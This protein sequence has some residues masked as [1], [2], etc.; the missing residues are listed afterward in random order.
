MN[1][2]TRLH[3]ASIFV[4]LIL[5]GG[6][7]AGSSIKPAEVA[8]EPVATSTPTFREETRES[9]ITRF[10]V[11]GDSISACSTGH[12]ESRAELM[13]G[14]W[15]TVVDSHPD[16]SYVGGWAQAGSL[17]TEEAVR[18]QPVPT[19]DVLVVMNGTNDILKLNQFRS[20]LEALDMIANTVGAPKV[21]LL[22]LPPIDYTDVSAAVAPHNAELA[23]HAASRGWVF[24]D[25][26]ADFRYGDKWAPGTTTDGV[27]PTDA[28][29]AR[30][31]E[32][33]SITLEGM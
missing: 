24:L 16:L 21:V 22:A 4:G 15:P 25:P 18:V 20:H 19:A 9:L 31:G 14:C 8:P 3:V 12:L 26:W 11:V 13:P 30:V 2:L 6:I 28:T 1:G 27:H 7:C 33:I 29:S 10:A 23:A 5:L 17:S 32:L